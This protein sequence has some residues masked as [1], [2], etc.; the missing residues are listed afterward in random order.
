MIVLRCVSTPLTSISKSLYSNKLLIADIK[1]HQMLHLLLSHRYAH[2]S[3]D[4]Q[5]K[6]L[7]TDP[8]QD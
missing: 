5:A 2:D 1:L 6:Q 7:D 8:S 3:A 4:V